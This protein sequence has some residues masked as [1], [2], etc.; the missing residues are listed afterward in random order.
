MSPA[1]GT[2]A[3]FQELGS[4]R[5]PD[6][7]LTMVGLEQKFGTPCGRPLAPV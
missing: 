5:D 7:T 6:R 3:G 2:R 1:P 4:D